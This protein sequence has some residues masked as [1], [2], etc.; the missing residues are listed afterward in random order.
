MH[1]PCAR[2]E[3][4]HIQAFL[5]ALEQKGY[6]PSDSKILQGVPGLTKAER[7]QLV[8]HAPMSVVELHTVCL[9]L[10]QLVE[11]L[12]QRMSDEQIEEILQCVMTHLP[13]PHAQV[14]PMEHETAPQMEEAPD[15][16]AADHM[17]MDEDAFPEEHFEHE[18]PQAAAA[19][20]DDD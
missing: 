1:R 19:D 7:L 14:E 4:G 11:E 13:A 18:A 6:A 12:G 9:S 2:Q 16:Y 5:Q 8:N 15:V 10:T 17:A 20:D 3:A